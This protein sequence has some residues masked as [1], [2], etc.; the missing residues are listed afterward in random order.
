VP[1]VTGA[2]GVCRTPAVLARAGRLKRD[3]AYE[4]PDAAPDPA[5][6]SSHDRSPD[7]P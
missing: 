2:G 5:A 1:Q 6:K 3:G 7:G 4:R